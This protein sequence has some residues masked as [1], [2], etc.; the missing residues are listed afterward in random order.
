MS[1]PEPKTTGPRCPECSGEIY[2]ECLMYWN[3][4]SQSF[5]PTGEPSGLFACTDCD[6]ETKHWDSL[7]K[8]DE[9]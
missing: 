3:I 1:D 6:F 5:E 8:E 4:D 2:T 9:I 7:I